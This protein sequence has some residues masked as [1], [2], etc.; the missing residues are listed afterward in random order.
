MKFHFLFLILLAEAKI[1]ISQINLVYNPSFEEYTGECSLAVFPQMVKYWYNP[2]CFGTPDYMNVCH[3]FPIGS[4]GVP[5][6][7]VG[8]QWPK[9]GVAYIFLGWDNNPFTYDGSREYIAQRIKEPLHE[10]KK[11]CISFWV[12]LA[13][14]IWYYQGSNALGLILSK[15]SIFA[16]SVYYLHPSGS[17]LWSCNNIYGTPILGD[18]TQ[19]LNDTLLWIKIETEYI[20][21]G[22]EEFL[23]IGN[24]FSSE[25]TRYGKPSINNDGIAG[26]FIDLIE[27]YL[28]EDTLPV[29]NDTFYLHIPNIF[30]P[31]ADGLNDAWQVKAKGVQQLSAAV[32]N[33]WGSLLWQQEVFADSIQNELHLSWDGRSNTGLPASAGTYYYL[34]TYTTTTGEIKK[35]KGFLTLIR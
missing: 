32:Y 10:S 34:V 25:Q 8:Y 30:T 4:L 2:D 9:D 13:D 3:S 21:S 5:T 31:N 29:P 22:G 28:C 35:E 15:D 27:L 23:A 19:I 26:Y 18:S 14:A 6:N 1:S 20:A 24:F 16:D 17:W 12:S 11:Y 7:Y 33:R